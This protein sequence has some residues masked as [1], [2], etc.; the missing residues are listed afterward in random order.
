MMHPGQVCRKKRPEI[1]DAARSPFFELAPHATVIFH[2]ER[3]R[4]HLEHPD[5]IAIAAWQC[6]RLFF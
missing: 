2:P 6:C 4:R 5:L 3:H 1:A